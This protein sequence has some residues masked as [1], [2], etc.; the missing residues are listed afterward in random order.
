[1]ITKFQ[2]LI[3]NF[4]SCIAANISID[5]NGQFVNLQIVTGSKFSKFESHVLQY[6]LG[7][8]EG[9]NNLHTVVTVL[10]P[11]SSADK[12]QCKFCQLQFCKEI[13]HFCNFFSKQFIA[14]LQDH[15]VVSKSDL[16]SSNKILQLPSY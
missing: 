16:L 12:L 5:Q 2:L 14:I 9:K 8:F 1:M 3:C 10:Q 7:W 13:S 15:L 11:V 4:I 6:K